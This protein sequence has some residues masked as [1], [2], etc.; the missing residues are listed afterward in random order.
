MNSIN[1]LQIQKLNKQ[2]VKKLKDIRNHIWKIILISGIILLISVFTPVSSYIRPG[3]Q[4]HVWL[5]GLNYFNIE[6]F[7]SEFSFWLLGEPLYINLS[8]RLVEIFIAIGITISSVKLI[9]IGNDIRMSRIGLKEQEQKLGKIGA[10]MIIA[11]IIYVASRYI[12]GN[13][14]YL[15]LG[16]DSVYVLWSGGSGP[17]FAFIGPFIGGALVIISVYASKKITPGEELI[18]IGESKKSI[19]NTS[20]EAKIGRRNYCPECGK[21][22]TSKESKFCIYCGFEIPI[23]DKKEFNST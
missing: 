15:F 6:G 14:Y 10:L 16:I 4:S 13:L 3:A 22:I 19:N 12:F 1:T 7:G 18:T 2:K 5:W 17:G 8:S 9:T 11:P 23:Y 20:V 21:K